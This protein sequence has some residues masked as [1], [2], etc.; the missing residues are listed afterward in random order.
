[1]TEFFAIKGESRAVEEIPSLE[2][3]I[4]TVRREEDNNR[5]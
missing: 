4:Y 5:S 3:I 2:F 1:M